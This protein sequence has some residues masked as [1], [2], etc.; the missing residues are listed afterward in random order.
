MLKSFLLGSSL[1]AFA[2]N[3]VFPSTKSNTP[4]HTNDYSHINNSLNVKGY[5]EL[6][7]YFTSTK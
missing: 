6:T 3:T 4:D 5:K 7:S 1:I 2:E